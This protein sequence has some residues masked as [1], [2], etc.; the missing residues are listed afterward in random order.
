MVKWVGEQSETTAY[1]YD[2]ENRMTKVTLP[3]ATTNEFV[4]DGDKRRVSSKNAAGT[5]IK[6]LYDGLN[7]LKDYA[8]DGEGETVLASYTQGI[9]IDKLISR[10][11]ASGIRYYH[12][13]ALGSTRLMTDGDEDTVATYVYDA[14]G[15]VTDHTG[16]STN[17]FKFTA[18]EF[19]DEIGLQYNCA[20]FYDPE[21][22]RFITQDPLTKGPDDP[23]GKVSSCA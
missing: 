19:E 13:D 15:K 5:M 3:N 14:W 10:T 20:R 23:K 2:Y 16:E 1:E 8:A 12:G 9:G 17:K 11:D 7:N 18:R 4:Y 22:G 6:F 21:T